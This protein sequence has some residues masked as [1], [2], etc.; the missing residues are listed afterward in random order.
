MLGKLIVGTD[1][2]G[3]RYIFSI[4]PELRSRPAYILGRTGKGKS[5]LLHHMIHQ[6]A[7]KPH[8]LVVFDAGDLALSLLDHLPAVTLALTW[9]HASGCWISTIAKG[10][11]N[12]KNLQ[13]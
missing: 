7:Q 8:A 1:V 4:A 11:E 12:G 9:E 2:I 6:D 13:S 3:R 5:T 10:G